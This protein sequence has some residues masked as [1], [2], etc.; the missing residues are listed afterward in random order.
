VAWLL[1]ALV[2]LFATLEAALGFCMGCWIYARLQRRGLVPA[3]ACTD[4]A[5]L[6][7]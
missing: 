1:V 4:C 6:E 7:S 3:D 2:V 5:P